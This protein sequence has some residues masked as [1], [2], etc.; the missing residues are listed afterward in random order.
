MKSRRLVTGAVIAAFLISA[1]GC[2]VIDRDLR[3]LR[4]CEGL[5]YVSGTGSASLGIPGLSDQAGTP[6]LAANIRAEALP[7]ASARLGRDLHTVVRLTEDLE[8]GS[9]VPS[10]ALLR[11]LQIA[12]D[13]VTLRCAEVNALGLPSQMNPVGP[14]SPD[15]GG[16]AD[17][18]GAE[19]RTEDSGA[20]Q[21]TQG[22]TGS[23][24]GELGSLR[25]EPEQR[26]GYDR[27]LFA[28]WIDANGNGC[29]TRREVLIRD[30]LTPVTVGPGCEISGGTWFSVYDGFTSSNPDDFDIDHMVALAEAWDSGARSWSDQR[31]QD[32]ANDLSFR[33]SLI[34]VSSSSNRSKSDQDPADWLPPN[35]AFHCDYVALWIEVKTL[36]D[37]SVDDAELNALEEISARC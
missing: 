7:Y 21:D 25:I 4:A 13:K 16:T 2:A 36:W 6:G 19:S 14:G 12:N 22:Q 29:D 37:L 27:D 10:P 34:A 9:V 35:E 24:T 20:Q 5:A 33:G 31:R 3:D 8:E 30:S 28:H 23:L 17:S 15:G 32:F 18:S 11:Q 26:A 1:S